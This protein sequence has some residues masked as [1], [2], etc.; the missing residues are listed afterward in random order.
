MEPSYDLLQNIC[1]P[2][3]N[4]QNGEKSVSN[5]RWNSVACL[6][7]F[8]LIL[9]S[10][11]SLILFSGV[12]MYRSIMKNTNTVSNYYSGLQKQFFKTLVYQVSAPLVMFHIPAIIV[13]AAPFFDSEFGAHSQLV[14]L[15]FKAYPLVES[16]IVL[17]VIPE[18]RSSL[19]NSFPEF[20]LWN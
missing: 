11:Y 3:E 7:C 14:L 13:L 19:K 18:Y 1:I 6:I 15:G 8:S 20:F 16:L 9:S 5:I 10:Q 12:T 2:L 4:L 17:D